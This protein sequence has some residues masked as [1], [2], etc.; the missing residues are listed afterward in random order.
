MI[1][2]KVK[3]LLEDSLA[4][5][6]RSTP[7]LI[8]MGGKQIDEDE[9]GINNL[10]YMQ[11]NEEKVPQVKN[12]DII[13]IKDITN[14]QTFDGIVLREPEYQETEKLHFVIVRVTNSTNKQIDENGALRQVRW[15]NGE[16]QYDGTKNIIGTVK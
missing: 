13:K 11:M 14:G 8:T 3:T 16:W 15:R 2:E 4:M 5:V 10:S 9:F 6:R 7:V 12:K 1:K